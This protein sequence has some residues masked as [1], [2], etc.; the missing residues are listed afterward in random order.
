MAYIMRTFWFRPAHVKTDVCYRMRLLLTQ[1]RDFK[2][3]VPDIENTIRR[4]LKSLAAASRA[5]V[6]AAL[7]KAVRAAVVDDALTR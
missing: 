2:R 1:R 4:S 3:R 5:P 6:A 7:Q